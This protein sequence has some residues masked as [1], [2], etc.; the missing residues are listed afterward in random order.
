MYACTTRRLFSVIVIL[1]TTGC[2]SLSGVD[3]S[4]NY[5][6]KA[7]DGVKCDSVSGTYYNALQNNLPSQRGT[8]GHVPGTTAPGL[9]EASTAPA[10]SM[11]SALSSTPTPPPSADTGPTMPLRTGPHILRLWIKPWEDSDHDLNGESVVYV[12]IDNGRWQIDHAR[13]RASEGFAPVRPGPQVAPSRVSAAPPSQASPSD[14][15][16]VAE[17][18]RALQRPPT[19]PSP[20]TDN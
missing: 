15:A 6:C 4:S 5:A 14:A 1:N 10:T 18:L 8:R 9:P 12:K 11:P 2:T 20:S 13:R 16:A 19:V 17:T 7:P 3:G